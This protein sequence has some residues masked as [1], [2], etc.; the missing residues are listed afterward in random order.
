MLC[1]KCGRP[2][3]K[4]MCTDDGSPLVAAKAKAA[5]LLGAVQPPSPGELHLMNRTLGLDLRL[6]GSAVIGRTAGEFA[7]LL[8]KYQQISSQH[9]RLEQGPNRQWVAV[10][11]G[12]TNGTKYNSAQLLPHVAQPLADGGRLQVA[13]IEFHVQLASTKPTKTGTL[14]I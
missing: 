3:A 12:S 7:A 9:V 10:D 8:G 13:N 11:L 14:R 4:K 6:T 5:P 1:P 2:G